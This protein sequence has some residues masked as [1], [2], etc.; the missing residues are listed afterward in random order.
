MPNSN[1][2]SNFPGDAKGSARAINE[3]LTPEE[4]AQL[5]DRVEVLE[6]RARDLEAQARIME[7]RVRLNEVQARMKAQRVQEQGAK[8]KAP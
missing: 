6:L 7:A 4:V 5:K 1:P 8:P 3:N 2:P